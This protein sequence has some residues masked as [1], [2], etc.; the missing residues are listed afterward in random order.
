LFLNPDGAAR[1]D[2]R[3]D[4]AFASDTNWPHVVWAIDTGGEHGIAYSA[5]DGGGWSPT[6][7]PVATDFDEVDPRV[8]VS[9]DGTVYVTWWIADLEQVWMSKRAAGAEDWDAPEPVTGVLDSGRR[10]SI[11][12][13]DGEVLAAYERDA[14]VSGQEVVVATRI[15][16]GVYATEVVATTSSELPLDVLLHDEDGVLWIDW[17]NSESEY[18]YSVYSDAAWTERVTLP[19]AGDS[20]TA[21]EEVRQTIRA[22][23]LKD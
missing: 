21:A 9:D 5:W 3:P 19:W 22:V 18:A 16:E 20:W 10:P 6:E 2:G 4:A 1:D 13:W 17:R 23:V 11:L 7:F 15:G 14:P 12:E 8:S